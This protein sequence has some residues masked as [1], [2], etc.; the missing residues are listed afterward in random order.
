MYPCIHAVCLLIQIFQVILS[1]M[2]HFVYVQT[3]LESKYFVF[4]HMTPQNTWRL[5]LW[6]AAAWVRALVNFSS[7]AEED[8]G[9]KC[10]PSYQVRRHRDWDWENVNVGGELQTAQTI[11]PT[12]QKIYCT[13]EK[14]GCRVIYPETG[15]WCSGMLWLSTSVNTAASSGL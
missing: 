10:R 5:L 3:F 11:M 9:R 7:R 8:V 2:G 14:T 6:P 13:K 12:Q 4:K 15:K 1:R